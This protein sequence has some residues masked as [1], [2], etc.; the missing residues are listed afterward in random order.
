MDQ[1]VVSLVDKEKMRV[2]QVA[3]T[4]TLKAWSK[5][6]ATARTNRAM[7]SAEAILSDAVAA[8][9]VCIAMTAF[10]D[11]VFPN[12]GLHRLSRLFA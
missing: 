7:E 4:E 8:N 10:H 12:V 9:Q 2:K 11:T 1:A 5:S 6:F 3:I